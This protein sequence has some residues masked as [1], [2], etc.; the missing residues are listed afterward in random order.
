[1]IENELGIGG[2]AQRPTSIG[3]G[4]RFNRFVY[5][6]VIGVTQVWCKHAK[7]MPSTTKESRHV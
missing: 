7:A 5:G 4:Q 3:L 1:M 6:C 2:A